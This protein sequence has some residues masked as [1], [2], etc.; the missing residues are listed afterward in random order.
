MN[1]FF[2]N[3]LY[4]P[5]SGS[6]SKLGQNPGSG[7]KFNV[8]GSTTTTLY[9]YVTVHNLKNVLQKFYCRFFKC[10]PGMSVFCSKISIIII[11]FQTG[12]HS[13]VNKHIIA[14]FSLLVAQH[15]WIKNLR[16]RRLC[17]Q[18]QNFTIQFGSGLWIRFRIR[19]I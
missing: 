3:W 16:D 6:G 5:G 19:P 18:G 10:V 4:N 11:T 2:Q 8:F 12:Y 15:V 14:D 13:H 9:R 17:W 7:S 1:F